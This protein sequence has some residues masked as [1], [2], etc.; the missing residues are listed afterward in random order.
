MHALTGSRQSLPT[1][2]STSAPAASSS[3]NQD[4]RGSRPGLSSRGE[5]VAREDVAVGALEAGEGGPERDGGGEELAFDQPW[6]GVRGVAAGDLR[7]EREEQLI[8]Q[9]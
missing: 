7:G 8:E 2:I 6:A 3:H 5:G 1:L 9:G 4:R